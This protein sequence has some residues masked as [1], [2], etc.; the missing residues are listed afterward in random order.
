MHIGCVIVVKFVRGVMWQEIE[1][2]KR[3]T[4]SRMMLSLFQMEDL[5]NI[6]VRLTGEYRW[7]MC[8]RIQGARWNLSIWCTFWESL[9]S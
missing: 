2:R 4:P 5:N 3:T 1:G 8:K 7:E 6:L 9:I